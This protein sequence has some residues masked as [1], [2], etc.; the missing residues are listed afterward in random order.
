MLN[1]AFRLCPWNSWIRNR[2]GVDR[3]VD[4]VSNA[5]VYMAMTDYPYNTSFL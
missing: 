3:L 4:W 2:T 5:F 1:N